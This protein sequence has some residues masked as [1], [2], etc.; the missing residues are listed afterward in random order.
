MGREEMMGRMGWDEAGR[1]A[2]GG[3]WKRISI[4]LGVS[5]V[6]CL[7]RQSIRHWTAGNLGNDS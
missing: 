1:Q 7:V 2:E 6:F 3:R 4:Y 5:R